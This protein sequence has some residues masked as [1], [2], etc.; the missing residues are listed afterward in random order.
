M[1]PIFGYYLGKPNHYAMPCPS[2]WISACARLSVIRWALREKQT[3]KLDSCLLKNK[4]PPGTGY[5]YR[6]GLPGAPLSTAEDAGPVLQESVLAPV[7]R[8]RAPACVTRADATAER[9]PALLYGDAFSS[10]RCLHLP[11]GL[12]A[13]LGKQVWEIKLH[14]PTENNCLS[15]AGF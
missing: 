6:T 12:F 2:R 11:R 15:D 10:L 5:S 9:H 1:T 3:R 14:E 8:P 7:P 4:H 13:S